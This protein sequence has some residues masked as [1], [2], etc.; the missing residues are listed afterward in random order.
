ML[1]YDDSSRLDKRNDIGKNSTKKR[2]LGSKSCTL[3]LRQLVMRKG[4]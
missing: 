4:T 3:C 2:A 1:M